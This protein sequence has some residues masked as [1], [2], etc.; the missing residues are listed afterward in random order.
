MVAPAPPPNLGH[1]PYPRAIFPRWGLTCLGLG[2]DFL[3]PGGHWAWLGACPVCRDLGTNRTAYLCVAYTPPS[4]YLSS[5]D[6]RPPAR[7]LGSRGPGPEPRSLSTVTSRC[8]PSL[9][10]SAVPADNGSQGTPV[11]GLPSSPWHDPWGRGLGLLS[12][13]SRVLGACECK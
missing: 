5:W 11:R 10:G 13:L 8:S 7:S 12:G 2:P 3:P 9:L 1:F 4:L 6:T